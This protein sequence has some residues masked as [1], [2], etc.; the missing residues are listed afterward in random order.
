MGVTVLAAAD[1]VAVPWRN[2]G[3]V[4]REIAVYPGGADDFLW[5]LSI[6][7]VESD[8]PFSAFPG[9]RRVITV[10]TGAGMRLTVDGVAH[11][12]GP[13]APF[14]FPGDAETS[15]VLPGGPVTDLN[16]IV[17]SSARG[18]VRIVE[19]AGDL[20]VTGPAAIVV[21]R[22]AVTVGGQA[23]GVPDAALVDDAIVTALRPQPSASL[24][25]VELPAG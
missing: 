2:G 23:L 19:P 18:S 6:A 25:L 8:G 16:L 15:C 3:G 5:R 12:I 13:L 4:T 11:E 20:T 17:Q 24:A 21:V 1:R 10:L 9:C 22:G 14:E 7:D